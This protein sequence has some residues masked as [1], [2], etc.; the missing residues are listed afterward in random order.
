MPALGWAGLGVFVT[1]AVLQVRERASGDKFRSESSAAC[2][3]LV[4]GLV[5]RAGQD[6][7]GRPRGVRRAPPGF[8]GLGQAGLG[9]K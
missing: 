4:H 5:R 2:P 9:K 7:Q 3:A 8:H 1:P 6:G